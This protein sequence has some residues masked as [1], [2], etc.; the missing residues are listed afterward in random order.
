MTERHVAAFRGREIRRTLNN[1]ESWFS[2]VDV[3]AALTDSA[4]AGAY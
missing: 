4:N 2:V 1:N 3:I